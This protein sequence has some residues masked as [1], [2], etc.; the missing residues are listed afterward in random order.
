MRMTRSDGPDCPKCGKAARAPI[1]TLKHLGLDAKRYRCDNRRCGH[2][3]TTSPPLARWPNPICPHC[4]N[5]GRD[6]NGKK[7]V[8]V[9][10][11]S[12]PYRYHR[13]R[14]CGATFMSYDRSHL[15]DSPPE[16]SG[17]PPGGNF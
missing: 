12:A 14:T 9:T 16:T 1:R 15:G 13:C 17:V 4:L 5:Y 7:H 10:H 2:E 11:T 8:E 3:W 6:D